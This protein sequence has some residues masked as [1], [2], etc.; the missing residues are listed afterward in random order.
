MP[1]KAPAGQLPRSVDII[2]DNDLVDKCK[3]QALFVQSWE[4]DIVLAFCLLKVKSQNKEPLGSPS[5]WV[6]SETAY[7]KQKACVKVA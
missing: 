3:V 4:L 6:S 5:N 1:E 2:A 7:F